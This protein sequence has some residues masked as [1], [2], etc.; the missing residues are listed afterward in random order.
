ILSTIGALRLLCRLPS[1]QLLSPAMQPAAATDRQISR[2]IQRGVGLSFFA[3][4]RARCS[5]GPLAGYTYRHRRQAPTPRWLTGTAARRR[6]TAPTNSQTTHIAAS[7]LRG[8]PARNWLREFRYSQDI[9]LGYQIGEQND[10]G[11]GGQRVFPGKNR[12]DSSAA[13]G[14]EI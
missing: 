13:E 14:T 4:T 11:N 5:A 1:S 12:F 9:F 7:C 2:P 10:L 8:S 6:A 3:A